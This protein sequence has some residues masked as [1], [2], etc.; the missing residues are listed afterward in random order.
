MNELLMMRIIKCVSVRRNCIHQLS[1]PRIY[2]CF[3]NYIETARMIERL[4][5]HLLVR[6]DRNHPSLRFLRRFSFFFYYII[7]F[8]KYIYIEN[9]ITILR[10]QRK[11]QELGR[12]SICPITSINPLVRIC[13]TTSSRLIQIR[14]TNLYSKKGGEKLT[15]PRQ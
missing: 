7:N 2:T 15:Y 4:F 8:N 9:T 1:L 12:V 14:D 6:L 11:V 5:V 3:F 10:Q 13:E